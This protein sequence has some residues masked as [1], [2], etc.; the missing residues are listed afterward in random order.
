[1]R[2]KAMQTMKGIQ[3]NFKLK[4]DNMEKPGVYLGAD[5]STMDNEHGGK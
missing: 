1:M 4:D 3:S 2:Y 5:L